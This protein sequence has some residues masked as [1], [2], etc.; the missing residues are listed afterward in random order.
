VVWAHT[1]SPSVFWKS[2]RTHVA[3]ATQSTLTTGRGQ[4][5]F[6]VTPFENVLPGFVLGMRSIKKEEGKVEKCKALIN[7]SAASDEE[8]DTLCSAAAASSSIG[9]LSFSMRIHCSRPFYVSSFSP[10][11]SCPNSLRNTQFVFTVAV[12]MCLFAR[13]ITLAGSCF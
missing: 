11:N 6:T 10:W 3:T 2:T 9:A 8:G 13:V 1:S 7:P 12:G 5:S 4:G